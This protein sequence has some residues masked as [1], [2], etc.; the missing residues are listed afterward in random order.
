MAIELRQFIRHPAGVPIQIIKEPGISQNLTMN[1]SEGGLSFTSPQ[2]Y[3]LGEM[4]QVRISLCEPAFSASGV[5]R[6]CKEAEQAFM[7][8]VSFD[9]K[10]VAYS[11]RMVEQICHIESYRQ[12]LLDTKGIKLSS[13]QAAI[14][15]VK[16]NAAK[17]KQTFY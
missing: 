17:F 16:H 10:S 11:L 4:I 2:A 14:E 13:E 1:I 12:Q 7:I 3:S 15:W 8:G 9:D 6:W 5:I